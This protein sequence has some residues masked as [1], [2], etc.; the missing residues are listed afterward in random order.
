MNIIETQQVT[1]LDYSIKCEKKGD[2]IYSA[3]AESDRVRL[4]GYF[5]DTPEKVINLCKFG[6]LKHHASLFKHTAIIVQPDIVGLVFTNLKAKTTITRKPTPIRLLQVF[7]PD[8]AVRLGRGDKVVI[9]E[10]EGKKNKLKKISFS[11]GSE[12]FLYVETFN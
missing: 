11:L 8:E 2:G 12:F 9:I 3:S 1:F 7:K 5:S 6:A 10:K 4:S